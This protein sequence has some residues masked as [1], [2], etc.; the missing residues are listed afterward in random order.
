[1]V[2]GSSRMLPDPPPHT[3]ERRGEQKEEALCTIGGMMRT[4]AT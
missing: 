2:C 3:M 1:M 4:R